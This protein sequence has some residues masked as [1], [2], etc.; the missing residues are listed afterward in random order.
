MLLL[1]LALFVAVL[2]GETYAVKTAGESSDREEL[3]QT[4]RAVRKAAIQ[5]YALDGAY[6][7]SYQD[8]KERTAIQVNEERFSVIYETVGS[9]IMP[10]ITVLRRVK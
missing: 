7:P 9:N 5:V 1:G 3:L 8:L 6:P 4:E 10:E 2:L